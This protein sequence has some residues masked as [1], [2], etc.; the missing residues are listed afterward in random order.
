MTYST[1]FESL[2]D[3]ESTYVRPGEMASIDVQGVPR[4][5]CLQL[6]CG[7]PSYIGGEKKLKCEYCKHPPVKHENMQSAA[8]GLTSYSGVP[9]AGKTDS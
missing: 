2:R 7:C 6:G 5:K 1:V 8:P 3:R 9:D 4:G